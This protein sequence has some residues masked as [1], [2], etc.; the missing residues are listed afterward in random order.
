MTKP[1]ERSFR[2]TR[3]SKIRIDREGNFWHEEERVEHPGLA[4]ALASWIAIDSETG[5]Y[6]LR[7]GLDWCFVTVDD[8]PLV[9]RTATVSEY[10]EVTLGLSDGTEEALDPATLRV[11][12]DGVVYCD[13][14][15]GTLPARFS[16]A[17][18]FALLS[19]ARMEGE[20]Y[21]LALSSGEHVIRRVGRGEG[22][23]RERVR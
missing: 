3:E 5:R 15:A 13:V 6:V 12:E 20:T 19:R 14:R 9:V 10:G 2:F 8:T 21:V 16:R 1:D 23:K 18:A 7:N 11:D 17:A 22:G 4:R